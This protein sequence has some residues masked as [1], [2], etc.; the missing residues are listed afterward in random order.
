ML[1]R[2]K[3]LVGEDFRA[4]MM[5]TAV[6][7]PGLATAITLI[8]AIHHWLDIGNSWALLLGVVGGLIGW[9]I[10]AA[11]AK[12]FVAMHSANPAVYRNLCSRFQILDAQM[13]EV[14]KRLEGRQ[15]DP[16][17][18]ALAE[19]TK[20]RSL[21]QGVFGGGKPT[22]DF[23]AQDWIGAS[24][25]IRLWELLHR[26][27]E[28]LLLLAPLETV[29]ADAWHDQL[30][31]QGSNIDSRDALSQC[32]DENLKLLRRKVPFEDPAGQPPQPTLSDQHVPAVREMLRYVRR[33]I[34][35]FR[36][37]R[38]FGLV[39]ARNRLLKTVVLTECIGFALAALAVIANATATSLIAATAFFLVGAVVGLFNQLYLD[40]STEVATEDYGLT[41]AR[42][43]HTPL[44]S[45][46]AALGGV[47]LIPILTSGVTSG[48]S[49]T[50]PVVLT[51]EKVF[52]L[53]H[54]FFSFLL[55]AIFGLT[56]TVLISRLHQEAERY[57]A[58]L[59]SSEAP[60]QQ[61]SVASPNAPPR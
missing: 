53:T 8:I 34:N 35:E 16:I 6:I 51:L 39:Q 15:E 31:L 23:S 48:L 42:L 58:D 28:A 41:T 40:A 32:L 46:L 56:P 59:K 22:Q 24:G 43:L 1:E 47:V 45:G 38:R 10:C 33:S 3:N 25:Y 49:D 14:G 26:A 9:L 29:A 21:L 57:K 44:F 17:V 11:I 2:W 37:E 60:T 54:T 20:Y 18:Y 5:V 50:T 55:A 52:D 61:G 27:E 36:D 19:V 7:A 12:N 30:R 4:G 13:E